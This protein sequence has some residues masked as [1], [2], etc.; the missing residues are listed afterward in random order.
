MENMQEPSAL[1]SHD[2]PKCVKASKSN[3]GRVESGRT[4]QVKRASEAEA[5][6]RYPEKKRA[7]AARRYREKKMAEVHQLK[8]EVQSLKEELFFLRN[9]GRGTPQANAI[10]RSVAATRAIAELHQ[11]TSRL[12]RIIES[13]L[14]GIKDLLAQ[15]K[16]LS[17]VSSVV[18]VKDDDLLGPVIQDP[19][20]LEGELEALHDLFE[21]DTSPC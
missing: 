5:A 8:C 4:N 9:G 2:A 18:D 19:A 13:A 7:E 15:S 20:S 1:T 11:G 10:A 21:L 16:D 17:D 14:D 3:V 12:I 6:R